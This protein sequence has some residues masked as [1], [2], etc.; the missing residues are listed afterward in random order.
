[1]KPEVGAHIDLMR[2]YMVEHKALLDRSRT[3]E[4]NIRD[5]LQR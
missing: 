2:V 4:H 3:L 5:R 1:L